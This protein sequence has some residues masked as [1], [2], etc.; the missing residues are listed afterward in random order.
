MSRETVL[1]LSTI[2]SLFNRFFQDGQ[3]IFGDVL[4]RWMSRTDAQKRLF[5]VTRANYLAQS[6][7]EKHIARRQAKSE[8]QE[9]FAEIFQRRH[10]CIHTCDRPRR[11]PQPMHQAATVVNTIEDV[12]YLVHRCDEH[13]NTEFR[14][15]LVG[16][17]CSV[18]TI[19]GA[20]Y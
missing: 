17:G 3:K 19:R 4:D 16:V 8:F 12:E 9:R 20:G 7:A 1:S 13:I 11:S 5:G 18:A 15:F 2:R 10:D 14:A 6:P